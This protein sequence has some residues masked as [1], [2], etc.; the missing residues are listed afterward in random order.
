M[1]Y[2]DP[3]RNY[4]GEDLAFLQSTIYRSLTWYN[5]GE[6]ANTANTLQP[7]MATDT[8]T[9][10]ADATQWSFTLRDGLTWQDGSAVTCAD[11]AYGTSRTFATDVINAGPTY[12][13]QYLD[14]PKDKAAANGTGYPGP[15][16]A[17]PAQQALFDKAVTCDGNTITFNLNQPVADFNY[18]VTLGFCAVPNPTDHPGVDTG[19]SY[20]A[21]SPFPMS[22]GPYKIDSYTT[23][24]GGKLILVRN[25]KWDASTDTVRK[26]YP[27]KWE[28]DFGIDPKV[29]DQRLLQS[30]GNDAYAVVYGLTQP[31]NL[32]TIFADENTPKPEYA[33]RAWSA[34]DP[35]SRYLW[36]DVNKVPNVKIRQAMAVAVDRAAY[37]LAGGGAFAGTLGDGVIKPNIGMDYAPTGM[38]TDM[39]GQA[40]PDN[41][42][43]D[44]AKQLI[45]QSGEAAPSLTYDFPNTPVHAKEADGIV[46]SLQL[47]GF[48]VTANPIEPGQY[49][50]IVFDDQKAHEFGYGGWGPD[51]PNASTVVPPL[52]TNTGGWNLS[53]VDQSNAGTNDPTWNDDVSAA[54]SEL[55]RPTQAKD[56][57][58]LNK[59][60]M[61]NVF[62]IP[63][64]FGLQQR[65]A[66]TNL[67]P[68]YQWPPYGSW[69]YGVMY[70]TP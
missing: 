4:T 62:V 51:W 20:G 41:G 30:Q 52:F 35:Y 32:P 22:D 49:Y 23:G 66:G 8:G 31:E 68:I 57:Q 47:A 3:Q 46:A 29:I 55:D 13:I 37:R 64:T 15:Y 5:W 44:L 39:F 17:T 42:D 50:G 11:V 56:W 34:F 48:N 54:L 19:E 61:Q 1:Q 65:L 2:L 45:S 28:M 27:D 67:G 70:V 43:P 26:A 14:I 40:I 58:D 33:G 6:D 36:I 12:A 9:P 60:A 63:T 16:T 21:Q 24:N 25:D 10:N 7:D 59:R 18:T 38:W 53:R 69:A